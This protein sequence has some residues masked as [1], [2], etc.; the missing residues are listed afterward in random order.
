MRC[1]ECRQRTNSDV[2]I[3]HVACKFPRFFHQ[4][5]ILYR[6]WEQLLLSND[7]NRFRWVVLGLSQDGAGTN[8]FENFREN[9]LKRGL[10]NDTT[11]NPPRFSLVN[12]FKYGVRS[13]NF[14][15][16][17]CAQLYSLAENPATPPPPHLGSYTRAL[18]VSQDRRHLF[19]TPW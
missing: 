5:P 6:Y 11:V 1:L 15:W 3:H 9:S 18:L 2:W 12:T 8:L 4:S 16:A 17:P 13:T 14:I 7:R 10:S 19:V